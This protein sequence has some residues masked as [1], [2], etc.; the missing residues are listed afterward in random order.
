MNKKNLQELNTHK[1]NI[2]IYKYKKSNLTH[3]Y[4]PI[5]EGYT[6]E[7]SQIPNS[8]TGSRDLI[9]IYPINKLCTTILS[10]HS[11]HTS[12]YTTNITH[13]HGAH[14]M[15][16]VKLLKQNFWWCILGSSTTKGKFMN[17]EKCLHE[18]LITELL[19]Q[20]YTQVHKCIT[21][22]M[23][24]R[25]A[26]F[27]LQCQLHLN[28]K[29]ENT[30]LLYHRKSPRCLWAF[31]RKHLLT[32]KIIYLC[33]FGKIAVGKFSRFRFQT[34][35]TPTGRSKVVQGTKFRS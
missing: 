5:C 22:S 10:C 8:R 13:L 9:N 34:K 35:I 29:L 32:L 14:K 30:L 15:H 33:Q 19:Q 12:V 6:L 16:Y 11:F 25:A 1:N 20:Q 28:L 26:Y 4:L 7:W 24:S 18:D 3:E 17:I 31:A 21:W 27:P 2:D 23:W